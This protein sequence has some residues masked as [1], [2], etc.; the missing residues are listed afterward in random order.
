MWKPKKTNVQLSQEIQTKLIYES[1]LKVITILKKMLV[2]LER[3]RAS[4]QERYKR[5]KERESQ[6]GSM[7]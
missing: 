5:R 7:L 2:Y 6:G 3:E 1:I 4:E